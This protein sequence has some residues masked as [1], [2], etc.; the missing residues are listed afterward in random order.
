MNPE[1]YP[2][3]KEPTEIT[4]QNWSNDIPP[5]LSIVNNTYNHENFIT[6]AIEGFAWY[7]T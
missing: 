6:A 5:L 1:S 7:F 3:L 2:F 4:K